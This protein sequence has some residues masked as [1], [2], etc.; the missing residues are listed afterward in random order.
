MVED[1]IVLS[2][3]RLEGRHG[4]SADERARPQSF[5]VAIECPTDARAAA[6]RDDIAATLDYRRLR[7][8][9]A[10]VIEGPP[11]ALVETLA[12]A[13]ASRIVAELG[14]R[15]VRVRVTKV[16]PPGLGASAS[17]EV[18]RPLVPAIRTTT[19]VELHV[20]DFAPVKDFYERLGFRVDREEAMT[21]DG[22]YLVLVRGEDRLSFWPGTPR[23]D[24]HSYFRRFPRG[25]TRGY[26][27]EIVLI[28]DDLDRLYEVARQ[29]GAVV[30]ELR[31][32]PWGARDFR[33]AD[34]FGFYLRFTEPAADRGSSVGHP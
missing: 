20:P 17:L 27:V 14:V 11:R 30:G 5:E 3:L 23:A 7:D 10:T 8:I 19:L 26:G 21:D 32:R 9:A 16:S 1:R 22:G 28:V 25:S 18:E 33:V 15:W 4:V 34:P 31:Q 13:I 24:E 6:E 29:M 2:G 12:D